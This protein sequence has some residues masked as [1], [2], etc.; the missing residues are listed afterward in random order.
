MSRVLRRTRVAEQ[1]L[2]RLGEDEFEATR[3]A[4]RESTRA[5]R[6]W[7]GVRRVFI[8]Q[9]LATAVLTVPV[10]ANGVFT[11]SAADWNGTLLVE[12]FEYPFPAL[13]ILGDVTGDGVVGIADLLGVFQAWGSCPSQPAGC[14]ADVDDDGTVGPADMIIVL[15]H[16]ST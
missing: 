1:K 14:P 8:G 15:G 4:L 10:D 16:W 9:P 2:R 5:G 12:S 7:S 13:G 6:L 11:F 3:A